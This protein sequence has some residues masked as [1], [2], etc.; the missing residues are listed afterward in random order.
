[1]E[2]YKACLVAKGFTQTKGLDYHENFTPIAKLTTVRCL[3]ALAAV[4]N[5]PLFQ[6]DVNNAFLHGDLHE[7]VYDSTTRTLLTRG[8]GCMSAS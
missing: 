5:W 6:M 3:L 7:E 2:R 8:E 4:R 1:V